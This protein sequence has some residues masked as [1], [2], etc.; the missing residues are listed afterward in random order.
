MN[1]EQMLAHCQVALRTALGDM[2]PRSNALIRFLFGR[3]AKK[4]L[5]RDPEFRRNLPTF[6]EARIV[7]R[8]VFEEERKRLIF[9]IE[10][11]QQGGPAGLT[12][13][14]H[15]F[16]GRMSVADWDTFQVKH[17]DHHLRQFGV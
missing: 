6:V 5:H 8:R 10:Q 17:L 12:A 4:Q 9:L 14:R 1:V 3:V 13:D 7:D 15:P 16:Y 11:F 2:T